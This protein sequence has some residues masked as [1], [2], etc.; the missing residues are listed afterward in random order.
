MTVSL[1]Q[2]K[3]ILHT[4]KG[5]SLWKLG[6]IVVF[7]IIIFFYHF[8]LDICQKSALLS[9]WFSGFVL[10]PPVWV[11]LRSW[12]HKKAGPVI[13]GKKTRKDGEFSQSNPSPNAAQANTPFIWQ[14]GRWGW[15]SGLTQSRITLPLEAL[16]L[17]PRD[18]VWL[19]LAIMYWQGKSFHSRKGNVYPQI[20]KKR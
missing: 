15:P 13:K 4:W 6:G 1:Y 7:I 10:F 17:G 16:K 19:T 18:P 2:I 14:T 8:L 9:H 5:S 3:I 11:E 20:K 12:K